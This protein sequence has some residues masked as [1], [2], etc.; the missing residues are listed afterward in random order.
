MLCDPF[1]RVVEAIAAN[2]LIRLDDRWLTPP[3]DECGVTGT[4]RHLLLES[5][6]PVHVEPLSHARLFDADG[7]FLTS[8]LLG[9][10][11]VA[12]LDG[13]VFMLQ[14]RPPELEAMNCAVF[15]F[16]GE[17]ACDE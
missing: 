4:V 3:L 17:T 15:H 2:L 13:H 16:A 7:L 6:L 12:T 11:P 10:R 9:I 8:A 14:E 1:D 5:T